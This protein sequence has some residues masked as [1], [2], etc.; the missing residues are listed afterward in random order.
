ME[1]RLGI[2]ITPLD[3]KIDVDVVTNDPQKEG[4]KVVNFPRSSILGKILED[5]NESIF[6]VMTNEVANYILFRGITDLPLLPKF[7]SVYKLRP[8]AIAQYPMYLGIAK[9]FGFNTLRLESFDN[10]YDVLS[11]NIKE[12]DFVFIHFKYTDMAGEDGDFLKKVQA[13]EKADKIL[14]Q[15]MKLDPDVV[16]VTGDHTTPCVYKSHGFQYTPYM[17]YS[18]KGDVLSI[19]KDFTERECLRGEL[20]I[21]PLVL[22]IQLMLAYSKR[23]QKFGA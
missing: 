21:F 19:S 18:K 15:I 22:N 23:L 3:G 4:M 1:H 11:Q 7:S 10:L 5:I 6:E 2:V 9:L 20:G 17:I 14:E 12:Y 16:V 8:L 13:I